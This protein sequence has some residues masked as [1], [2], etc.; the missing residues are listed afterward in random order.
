MTMALV[1]QDEVIDLA[2]GVYE[3]EPVTLTL[4]SMQAVV[5]SAIPV[6]PP[7]QWFD[8]PNLSQ[9]TPL[10]I[11]SDG[12]VF[13]HIAGWK[14]D[15]IG[16][17]GRIRAPH[18]KSDYAFF[19]TG[20]LETAEGEMVNVGQISHVG[21]H[22]PLEASVAEA[23]A[24]YDNTDSA[25]MDVAVGEDK[26][27]IWV[28]GALRPD[29]DELKLRRVRA[30]GVSGDWRPI[31]GHLEMVAVCSVNVPGFPTPRVRVAAGQPVAL[32]AAGTTEIVEAMLASRGADEQGTLTASIDERLRLVEDALLGRVLERREALL[33][34]VGEAREIATLEAVPDAES[35]DDIPEDALTLTIDPVEVLRAR[36]R[37]TKPEM[38]VAASLRAS[39]HPA[40][41]DGMG[42][43]LTISEC[44]QAALRARVRAPGMVARAT[45]HWDTAK[46]KAASKKGV[47]LPDGS[48]PISDKED[49]D[50]A[51]RAI[52]RAGPGKRAKVINHLLKRGKVLGIAEDKMKAVRAL[53]KS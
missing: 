36:V 13:G 41:I 37:G 12:R 17:N 29:V 3:T 19:A 48:Y 27:G 34:A 20:V 53:S 35:V 31:N 52:G 24:H 10:V 9:V 43:E 8:N 46:R 4:V 5:A 32:V 51:R 18:S 28:A 33:A 16:M 1:D 44:V 47:A 2:D 23:V 26:H 30:S 6:K 50:K 38:D 11:Q 7:R 49:W 22:A 42:Y 40:W 39:A 14:Q 45:S 15:H 25:V 21:G